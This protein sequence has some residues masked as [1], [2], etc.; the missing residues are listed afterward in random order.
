MVALDAHDAG[1]GDAQIGRREVPDAHEVRRDE[2]ILERDQRVQRHARPPEHVVRV[3]EGGE[4]R[5]RAGHRLLQRVVGHLL[6]PGGSQV[7]L[8]IALEAGEERRPLDDVGVRGH[9]E[10]LGDLGGDQDVGVSLRQAR[11][12]YRRRLQ[13]AAQGQ[14]CTGCSGRAY[15]RR[16]GQRPIDHV[17]HLSTPSWSETAASG[18]LVSHLVRA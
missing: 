11:C 3:V 13:E 7:A 18:R 12:P 14:T 2:R 9:R 8:V 16:A 15:Q 10:R 5:W 17:T 6:L 1:G 4:R